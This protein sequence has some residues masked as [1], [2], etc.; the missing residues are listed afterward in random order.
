MRDADTPFIIMPLS[1][2]KE[3]KSLTL[4]PEFSAVYNMLVDLI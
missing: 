4:W 2:T 1:L 3:F